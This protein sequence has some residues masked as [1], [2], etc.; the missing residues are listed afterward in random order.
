MYMYRKDNVQESL[1]LHE[2][3]ARVNNFNVEIYRSGCSVL[4][5]VKID[6]GALDFKATCVISKIFA[7]LKLICIRK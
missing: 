6:A 2:K 5:K 7:I 4:G 3:R 1:S